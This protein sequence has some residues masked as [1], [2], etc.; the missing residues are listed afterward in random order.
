MTDVLMT[1]DQWRAVKA[2]V[3]EALELPESERIAFLALRCGDDVS[4]RTEAGSLLESSMTAIDR[5]EAPLLT[6]S[7]LHALLGDINEPEGAFVGYRIGAYRI[8]GEIGRGGM[9][10][11]YLAERADDAFTRRVAIK[12]I[13]R[14][15]DTE[16][17]LRRFLHE[18]QILASLNHPNI[19]TLLD[20]GTTGDDRP[21]FVMEYVDGLPISEYCDRNRLPIPER[22]R[23]YL[24]VC[25]AVAHAHDNRVIHRDLKPG[26]ILVNNEGIVKLLDFGIAKVLDP[27]RGVH[28]VEQT[29]AAPAMT[30]EYASP[31]QVRGQAVTP[32]T[33]VYSLG[34]LL[35]EL[36]TGEN[37]QRLSG[38]TVR[39]VERI[40]CD[41]PAPPPST[42]PR[43]E[44]A[45]SR[46]LTR[47]SLRRHLR[48]NLDAIA[49][50]ALEKEPSRRYASVSALAEDVRRHLAGHPILAGNRLR[51]RYRRRFRHAVT[52]PAAAAALVGLAV[53]GALY[54]LPSRTSPAVSAIDSIAV[55]PLLAVTA[56]SPNAE[57]VAEGITENVTRRLSRLSQLTVIGRESAHRVVSR[58]MDPRAAGRALGVHAVLTGTLAESAGSLT[59]DAQVTDVRD[60]SRLWAEQ[61]VRPMS[62]L[63]FLQAELAAAVVDQL[64][65]RVSPTEKTLAARRES[66]DP[67]A[68]T[69]YLKGRYFWNKR[70]PED[71]RK[72]IQHFKEATDRDP[73]YALA[74][75]GLADAYALLTEYHAAPARETYALANRAVTRALTLD[76][77]LAEAH[78]SLAYIRT[79]YEWDWAGAETEFKRALELEPRY[80]TAHQWYAELLSAMERH[81][82]AIAEIRRATDLDPLSLIAH[83][84]HAN[85]LYFGRRY[86]ASIEMCRRVIDMDRNFPEVYEYL[87]RS[88]D[89]T[90]QYR[91]SIDARQTRRRLLGLDAALTPALRAAA[92]ASTSREYWQGRLEQELTEGKEEGLLP[93]EMAEILAQAGQTAHALDWLERACRDND[94]MMLNVRVAPNLDPL[95]SH[96]RFKAVLGRSCRVAP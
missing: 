2:I 28:T 38:Q 18:R 21:Y 26:N 31:E 24:A 23:L 76:D 90:G 59:L 1:P 36:L 63:Q 43:D 54:L 22:L 70:T 69:S 81:D 51:E 72:S 75:V 52:R 84:V 33:D 95:R 5:F 12:L 17:I 29:A 44:H 67:E 48:G 32:A 13:K 9:G 50:R 77:E 62:D 47:D 42:T 20:G 66:V 80:A 8:I 7:A 94:F 57:I 25:D 14:G 60:G 19:A 91:L 41:A 85:L 79:F 46:S 61:F 45:S 39:E 64:H 82:E 93:F 83:S 68:Y 11:A 87:K 53:I 6:Q 96:P 71:F 78:A 65:L 89:Q 30:L 27:D 40:I 10:A 34:I 37:P 16:A 86:D 15:M 92:A 3:A 74:Y 58:Q 73:S 49:L 35:Y 55:L 88:Y 4:L 56:D